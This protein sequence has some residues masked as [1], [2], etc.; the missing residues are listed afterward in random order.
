M[1]GQEIA[2]QLAT[3]V[4]SL[5]TIRGFVDKVKPARQPQVLTVFRAKVQDLAPIIIDLE[6][7]QKDPRWPKAVTRFNRRDRMNLDATIAALQQLRVAVGETYNVTPTDEV[8]HTGGF[9]MTDDVNDQAAHEAASLHKS[10]A[11][12]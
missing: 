3:I 8:H 9:L 12:E 11:S 5:G 2:T 10:E 4:E 1:D 7:L 6:G